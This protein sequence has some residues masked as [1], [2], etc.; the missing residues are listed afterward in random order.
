[1]FA[2]RNSRALS[3]LGSPDVGH[4]DVEVEGLS[5]QRVVKRDHDGFVLDR[6]NAHGNGLT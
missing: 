6:A 4:L 3:C 2:E 1:M 5:R